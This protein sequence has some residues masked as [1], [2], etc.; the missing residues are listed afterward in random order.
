[1]SWRARVPKDEND[2]SATGEEGLLGSGE[3]T[4]RAMVGFFSPFSFFF[5]FG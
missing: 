3:R 2:D 4:R 5:S 1:V